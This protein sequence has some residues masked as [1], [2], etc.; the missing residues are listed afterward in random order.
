MGKFRVIKIVALLLLIFVGGGVAGILLDRHFTPR[1]STPRRLMDV[2]MAERPDYLL[3]EFT[4]AMKLNS[5][6]QRRVG[7]LIKDWNRQ[8]AAHPE[9]SR[10]QRASFIETNSP[11]LRTNL[12]AEQSVIFDR[13][14]ERMHRR[15][16]R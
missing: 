12:S 14:M 7:V 11:T 10:S 5:D 3:K 13:L 16:M 4:T 8:I 9:W 2:P 1:D 15:H 6:Q